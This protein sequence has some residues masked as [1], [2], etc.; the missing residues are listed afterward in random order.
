MPLK[1]QLKPWAVDAQGWLS[2]AA[3]FWPEQP[4]GCCSLLL[5]LPPAREGGK[6]IGVQSAPTALPQITTSIV[7]ARA[8]LSLMLK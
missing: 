4:I 8:G 7:V 1:A 2:G 5:S 3:P 6:T